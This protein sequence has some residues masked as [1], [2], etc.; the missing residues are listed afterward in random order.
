MNEINE[1]NSINTAKPTNTTKD[2]NTLNSAN[3]EELE[4]LFEKRLSREE[5]FDGVVLHADR[6]CPLRFFTSRQEQDG[7]QGKKD[8]R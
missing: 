1:K 8:F 4:R 6:D 7:E 5:I 3:K 2:I